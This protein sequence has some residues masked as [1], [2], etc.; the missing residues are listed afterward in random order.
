MFTD[1]R[2]VIPGGM[3]FALR[4]E[5]FDGNR[6]VKEVLA[7]GAGFAVA[8]DPAL[9]DDP[10]VLVVDDA[11][12]ALQRLAAHHRRELGI[13]ILAITGSNGKTTTKE[14]VSRV[15]AQKY[16]VAATRGNL[17]NHI[18]VPLTL[19]AMDRSVEFGVV[20][21]GASAQGEIALLCSIA[22]PDYGIITNIGRS[23]LEGFGG[24]G[25]IEKGKG[26]MF[27]FLAAHHGVAF[28]RREDAVLTAMA[29]SRDGLKTV[30][31]SDERGQMPSNL[32]GEYNRFNI[33]A[34]SAIGEYFGVVDGQVRDAV[35]GYVPDNNRS[36]AVRT[37]HNDLIVDCYNA[38]PSSMRAALDNFLERKGRKAVILGDMLE[39]GEWSAD[40]HLAVMRRLAASEP[41]HIWLVGANF[42]DAAAK[43]Q[44]S[45]VKTYPDAAALAA[46]FTAS[47][48]EGLTILIKGSHSIRL[49]TLVGLL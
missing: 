1:S 32:E 5:K 33:A 18:G 17:N 39:L 15:L 24:P 12:D 27:D 21:M 35:A 43:C 23:H 3:F 22:Q 25:G 4:G 44:L 20:E 28:V 2:Q 34:A 31:Y 14:L 36:Q 47:R 8:D 42:A 19:L 38:N 9:A 13:P 49:E 16:A 40:E 48:P 37:A 10:R 29:A 11:L 41:E 6:F 45:G 30:V 7:A 26:E 46:E